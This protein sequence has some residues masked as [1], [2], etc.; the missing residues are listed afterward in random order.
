MAAAAQSA[1][2]AHRRSLATAAAAGAV[3][4][5]LFFVPTAKATP[6]AGPRHNATAASTHSAAGD[7]ARSAGHATVP[8]PGRLADTGSFDTAPYMVGGLGFLGAGGVL[9]TRSLRGA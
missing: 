9:V 7:A 4:I 5:A 2:S 6:D 1:M 3:L 8:R